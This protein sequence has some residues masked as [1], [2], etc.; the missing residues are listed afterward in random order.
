MMA[1]PDGDEMWP[2]AAPPAFSGGADVVGPLRRITEI[3][4]GAPRRAGRI[5]F[6]VRGP[7]GGAELADSGRGQDKK[8]N[9]DFWPSYLA[10]F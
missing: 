3:A 9:A 10:I 2:R 5:A 8:N 4:G 1:R 6:D 7:R